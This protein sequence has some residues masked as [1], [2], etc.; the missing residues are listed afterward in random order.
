M[1]ASGGTLGWPGRVAVGVLHGDTPEIFLAESDAVLGRLLA[2]RLV[3]PSR[4]EDFRP[5]ELEEIRSALL[6]QRW[7]DAVT[8]WMLA[9]GDV[10]DGY[11]DE[12]IVT[13]EMLDDDRASMEIRLLPIFQ[14]PPPAG[15]P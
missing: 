11:P 15:T 14:E 7:A 10:L 13:E 2:V 9:T 12:Q 3:G 8:A 4:P 6:E 5:A 1:G